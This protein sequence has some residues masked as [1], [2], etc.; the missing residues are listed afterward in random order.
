[1]EEVN[2]QT[3]TASTDVAKRAMIDGFAR[4]VKQVA[5]V[6]VILCH[7]R[8]APRAY[9]VHGLTLLALVTHHFFHRVAIHGVIT[10]VVVTKS[11]RESLVAARRDDFA[12]TLVMLATV[13]AVLLVFVDGLAQNRRRTRFLCATH[14]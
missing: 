11:A 8:R 12:P 9:L 7:R 4:V 1:M 6:A 10:R 2:A 14:A 13:F 3:F 5:H